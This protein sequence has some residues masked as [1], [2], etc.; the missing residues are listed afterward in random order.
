MRKSISILLLIVALFLAPTALAEDN[1]I[2]NGGFEQVS[3]AMPDEWT[4]GMW[5][6][7]LGASYL[8]LAEDTPHTGQIGVLVE[9]VQEN[10]A[11]FEQTLSVKP[12]TIYKLTAYVMAEDVNPE[13][14]GANISFADVYGTS[15]E[16]YDT[17]GEWEELTIYGRTGKGQKQ[18]TVM[19]RVG[20]Y[21]SLNTGRA[22]FDDVSLVKVDTVPD[23]AVYYDLATPE[24]VKEATVREPGVP[25]NT[26]IF[27]LMGAGLVYA[28]I[29]YLAMS[30]L[31]KRGSGVHSI[32]AVGLTLTAAFMLRL[33]LSATVPGYGTDINCFASWSVTM[34]N[35]GPSKFYQ[36]T[37]FCDYPPAYMLVLWLNG[38][39]MRL[40]GTGYSGPALE[41]VLKFVPIVCDMLAAILLYCFMKKR[42]S[43]KTAFVFS[44]LYAFNPA[45]IL[46]SSCWGQIDSVL[47]LALIVLLMFAADE[48]WEIAIPVYA[49]AALTKPQAFLFAPLG[50]CALIRTFVVSGEQ[51]RVVKVKGESGT[52]ARLTTYTPREWRKLMGRR[53]L[54]GVGLT[55]VVCAAVIVPFGINQQFGWLIDKY[56]ETLSSYNCAT[57]ST[58]NLM[59]LL[60]GNWVDAELPSPLGVSYTVLGWTLMIL[61]IAYV[62]FLTL[63]AKRKGDAHDDSWQAL[64]FE[65]AALLLLLICVFGVKMHE[66]YSLPVL[67][68]LLFA[69]ARRPDKRFMWVFAALS[70]SFTVNCGIVLLFE[71]LYYPNLWAGNICSVLNIAAA[72]LLA[73]ICYDHAIKGHVSEMAIIEMQAR[74]DG[75]PEVDE[76]AAAYDARM[77]EA[78]TV[79]PDSGLH[80]RAKDIVLMCVVTLVYGVVA[81][82]NL[83]STVAPQ[84]GY[85][86]TAQGESVTFDLGELQEDFYIYYYGG[87]SDVSFTVASSAD[88]EEWS[89]EMP[90]EFNIGL[91]FRWIAHKPAML[92][93]EGMQLLNDD[94]ELR[95]DVGR[96]IYTARYM[97]I[98]FDGAGADIWEVGF[99]K[100][101]KP[102]PIVSA[103]ASGAIP[104]RA[105]DAAA[106]IDEQAA[107]PDVPTYY[108]GTYF[109]EIYH[110]RTAYEHKESLHAYETSHPPLGK[111]LIMVGINLFGMTP[112][113]WRC[114]GTFFGVLMLPLI[115]LMGKQLFKG[116]I[117]P[118][119]LCMVLFACDMMHF[120]Q[121]RIS[122]I[123]TYPVF[124][125]MVMY[126]FMLRYMKVSFFTQKLHRTL[127]PLFFS[128]LFMGFA[129]ASKW[130]GI[131][132]AVG[133]AVLFFVRLFGLYR[134][135]V[136]ARAHAQEDERFEKAAS[137]FT[138][139]ALITLAACCVF[140]IA[141]PLVIYCLSFIPHLAP[142][143][144][145]TLERIWNAQLSMLS[146]HSGL[147]DP[148]YFQSPWYQWPLIIKPMW[149]FNADYKPIGMV[150]TILAFG[151]PAVWW[152]GLVAIVYAMVR[153]VR[154]RALPMIGLARR[155]EDKMDDALW[156]ICVGMLSQYLPWVLVPRSTF[157]YHYFASVPFII[158]A[159]GQAYMYIERKHMK[160]A[161]VLAFALMAVAL[162]LF[163]GFYPLASGTVVSRTW[164][165]AMSWFPRW[166]WY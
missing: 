81:F 16:L 151:N 109:D 166:L 113:G 37:S 84:S 150:S 58:G 21:G 55:L 42:A 155:R 22:W 132:A 90:A 136:W 45:V 85:I 139:Y 48:R 108:N 63:R 124:F 164:A 121:T 161:R 153:C 40:M 82:M 143:G 30:A 11:R 160:L 106:L 43:E 76:E 147:V 69:Y 118:S 49:L 158:L 125:I 75:E 134:Q 13:A 18:L 50:I 103:S 93:E 47:L 152:T 122:T 145:V 71:H 26:E 7:T 116:R 2:K 67:A 61:S 38:M 8:E 23:D 80:L 52:E 36:T 135:S 72:L 44:A 120:T 19:L 14:K 92:D 78:L 73:K 162:L 130:I 88:G 117:M 35:V 87:I 9:N 86:S 77:R 131:Y 24:P 5:V 1:L 142:D 159:T 68:L 62:A 95:W 99:V 6:N 112:F 141:I 128:G 59:F 157:I 104:T 146:Y 100:E 148:H 126:L 83:G 149:Y 123:D 94:G 74:P 91:C 89:S 140:F 25:G 39:M 51:Q 119:L 12:Q 10:D 96:A 110:A 64:L 57:L 114:V 101:G 54:I 70:A 28:A 41:M 34:A 129:I 56:T 65:Q 137:V 20:G 46:V 111:L 27:M 98:T 144:K 115:Y 154:R 79:K 165:E 107:V 53:V 33:V 4:R 97:R 66:R 133:L 127:V 102:L 32:A 29:V 105:G 31:K 3:G 138:R 15:R 60:G 163:I 17:N 156:F